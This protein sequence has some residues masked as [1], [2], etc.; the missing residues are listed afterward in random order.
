MQLERHA[1]IPSVIK[2]YDGNVA[3]DS[4]NVRSLGAACDLARLQRLHDFLEQIHTGKGCV[5]DQHAAISNGVGS[6]PGHIGLSHELC[7][8]G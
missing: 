3:Y 5:Q 8:L 4:S 1:V 6:I 2:S 7:R